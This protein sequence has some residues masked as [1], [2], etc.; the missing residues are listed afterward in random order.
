LQIESVDYLP[1]HSKRQ[2]FEWYSPLYT[3]SVRRDEGKSRRHHSKDIAKA[4]LRSSHV[5]PYVGFL[6]RC[7]SEQRVN[8][9][10]I[11]AP[12]IINLTLFRRGQ[13]RILP[14][15]FAP[16]RL[17]LLVELLRAIPSS[18]SSV[19]LWLLFA[20]SQGKIR[21]SLYDIVV[22]EYQVDRVSHSSLA[23]R[24]TLGNL[25]CTKNKD[26]EI[27]LPPPLLLGDFDGRPGLR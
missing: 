1:R 14:S 20:L 18:S 27:L 5:G 15:R 19:H 24:S 12:T 6:P 16:R 13:R 9:S 7:A 11:S 21:K 22:L 4:L 8:G 26:N 23:S 10:R 2:I 25:V 3:T 17:A